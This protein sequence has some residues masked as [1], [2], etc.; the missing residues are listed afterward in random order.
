MNLQR[1]TPN[2]ELGYRKRLLFNM[3]LSALLSI[4]MVFST[5]ANSYSQ[6][7]INL[8]I[9]N[10]PIIKVLDKIESDTYLRFIFGSEIYD[11][12]KLISLS[13]EKA[14]LNEV[15][16]LIF[17]NRLSYDLNENVVLLKKS[18]EKQIKPNKM[19]EKTLKEQRNAKMN[20]VS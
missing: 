17:E 7:E 15:I 9:Q 16:K 20:D 13:V 11:F 3:K 6:V 14:K 19:Q 4:I 5:F 12:Q 8:D 1:I 18:I 2:H 10:Q